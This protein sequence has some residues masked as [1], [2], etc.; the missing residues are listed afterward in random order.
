MN[1]KVKTNINKTPAHHDVPMEPPFGLDDKIRFSE[2]ERGI[3]RIDD[4]INP[5]TTT[6]ILQ[7]IEYLKTK[8]IKKISFMITSLG[9]NLTIPWRC[10]I[11]LYIFQNKESKQML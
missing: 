9:G 2:L 1:K 11:E 8:G 5:Y 3:I 7:Q 4:M 10:M 6:S